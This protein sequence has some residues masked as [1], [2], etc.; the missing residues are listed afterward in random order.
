M[1]ID[2][3]TLNMCRIY[4]NGALHQGTSYN[5]KKAECALTAALLTEGYDYQRAIED[6]WVPLSTGDQ[7]PNQMLRWDEVVVLGLHPVKAFGS[8]VSIS[9]RGGNYG[10]ENPDLAHPLN[11]A[12]MFAR[13]LKDLDSANLCVIEYGEIVRS[14]SLRHQKAGSGAAPKYGGNAFREHDHS[15]RF[16]TPSWYSP[17]PADDGLLLRLDK[18]DTQFDNIALI[19]WFSTAGIEHVLASHGG[20]PEVLAE[21]AAYIGRDAKSALSAAAARELT[22]L[23]NGNRQPAY[24]HL[25]SLLRLCS[26]GVAEARI[27]EAKGVRRMLGIC[28]RDTPTT[29][30][31]MALAEIATSGKAGEVSALYGR[32][33]T[34]DELVKVRSQGIVQIL[35]LMPYTLLQEVLEESRAEERLRARLLLELGSADTERLRSA[36][37][38]HAGR[39]TLRP[40]PLVD[41]PPERPVSS[42]ET[43]THDW[44]E[45]FSKMAEQYARSVHFRDHLK[46][47]VPEPAVRVTLAMQIYA[48]DERLWTVLRTLPRWGEINDLIKGM[49]PPTA[50]I[51]A[52]FK[53]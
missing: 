22:R 19:G 13:H 37:S 3:V 1:V 14:L 32:A 36:F 26:R 5:N 40:Y 2:D 51:A 15:N 45:V 23:W 47:L 16:W 30:M 48:P 20:K 49:S 44:D 25:A 17:N 41:E 4:L 27:G 8:G 43:T 46:A 33:P 31:Q 12:L 7:A 29:H 6:V 42:T 21:A 11:I 38:D 34:V 39:A 28:R 52:W 10:S 35:Y 9:F 18:P 24:D 50:R 53:K